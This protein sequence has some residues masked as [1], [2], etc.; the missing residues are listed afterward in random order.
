MLSGE[1]DRHTGVVT[2][3]FLLYC[4]KVEVL[5]WVIAHE[6]TRDFSREVWENALAHI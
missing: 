6:S 2:D 5:L 4:R 1:I 3:N